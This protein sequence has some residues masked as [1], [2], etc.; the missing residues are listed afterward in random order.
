MEVWIPQIFHV[1]FFLSHILF[2]SS[3]YYSQHN[4]TEE[5]ISAQFTFARFLSV[6]DCSLQ[7]EEF[8]IV[9]FPSVFS[10]VLTLKFIIYQ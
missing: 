5:S 8:R 7:F 4:N 6:F 2:T 1:G 10:I 9:E 3:S